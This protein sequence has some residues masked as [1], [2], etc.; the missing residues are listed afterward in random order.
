MTKYINHRIHNNSARWSH[1]IC[2]FFQKNMIQLG[3]NDQYTDTGSPELTKWIWTNKI[4]V[5]SPQIIGTCPKVG[6]ISFAISWTDKIQKNM[7]CGQSTD[8]WSINTLMSNVIVISNALLSHKKPKQTKTNKKHT[9]SRHFIP[10][11]LKC[12]QTNVL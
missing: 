11:H 12:P 3:E 1:R 8:L 2:I 5:S 4:C 7:E 9:C 10:L 6:I